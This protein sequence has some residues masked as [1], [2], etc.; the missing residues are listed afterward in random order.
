MDFLL[1]FTCF[2]SV[3]V[4]NE[5][6]SHVLLLFEYAVPSHWNVI[7]QPTDNRSH[8]GQGKDVWKLGVALLCAISEG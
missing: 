2:H 8:N 3:H 5:H 7:V 4:P 1:T 6:A